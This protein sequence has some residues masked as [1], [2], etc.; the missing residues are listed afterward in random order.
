[1]DASCISIMTFSFVLYFYPFH[2]CKDAYYFSTAVYLPPGF[3]HDCLHLTV[4]GHATTLRI[5]TCKTDCDTSMCF[6]TESHSEQNNKWSPK[7]KPIPKEQAIFMVH[8]FNLRSYL[9]PH[10]EK[11][12]KEAD[13]QAQ[14][15]RSAVHSWDMRRAARRHVADNEPRQHHP[16]IPSSVFLPALIRLTGERRY[17]PF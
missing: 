4:F 14:D 9:L 17:V 12:E 13:G 1:M 3:I 5:N 2:F 8:E 7:H 16:C 10:G 11:Q 15:E 6:H